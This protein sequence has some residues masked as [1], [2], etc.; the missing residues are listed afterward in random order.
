M[1][2]TCGVSR[3]AISAKSA[4][5]WCQTISS[6]RRMYWRCRRRTACRSTR[7]AFRN[8]AIDAGIVIPPFV[9]TFLENGV[10]VALKEP[11]DLVKPHPLTIAVSMINTDFAKS[12]EQVM[13]NYYIAYLRSVRDYCNAYHGGKD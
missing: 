10:A 1:S 2:P 3:K 4:S 6:H 5:S 13:R 12:N 8:G 9:S 11:D 7:A